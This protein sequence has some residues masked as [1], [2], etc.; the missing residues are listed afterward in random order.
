[1]QLVL[2]DT[3]QIQPYIFSSSRLRENTGASDLVAA[4][5]GDWALDA[6][7]EVATPHNIRAD[8]SLDAGRRIESDADGPEAELVYAGGGNVAVL[9]R[10]P[11]SAEAF[12]R[13]L[14]RR[15]FTEAPELQLVIGRQ[16]FEWGESLADRLDSAFRT[17]AVE[18]RGRRLSAPLF[19]L[20]VS[21][22]CRSTGLPAAGLTPGVAPYP[23]SA[24]ILAKW[25]RRSEADARLQR[26]L[27]PAD[28]CD[29]PADFN[30]LCQ[31]EGEHSY[32][33]VVHADGNG[34][35]E[36]MRTVARQHR[37]PA[38]NRAFIEAIR[39]FS[40][41]L[42]SAGLS[43]LREALSLCPI[44]RGE[45][46]HPVPGK[47]GIS[48][49][50]DRE[51]GKLLLP[52]RP[53]VFGGD[54]VTFVSDGR[55]GLGLAVAYLEEFEKA[56][57]G[58]PGSTA[59]ATACAGV[60]IV[61]SHYPFA[62]A[63][64]LASD[65]CRAAKT[66]RREAH[67]EGSCLDWHFALSGLAGDLNEIRRR[68]Y[69]VP[70]GSLTLRPVSLAANPRHAH[71]SWPVVRAGVAAFQGHGWEGR[72]NKVKALRDALRSGGEAV[73]WFLGRF[74]EGKDL[75]DVELSMSDWPKRGWQGRWCGYFD[76]VEI[77]DW[78][79]PLEGEAH[80]ATGA[81]YH[82]A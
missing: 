19:G 50:T 74:N 21:V 54:D 36:R 57:A 18:K 51:T 2:V 9:F 39:G 10:S 34:T 25:E 32:I 37:E 15:V 64:A 78:F 8:G 77:A 61:K 42:D 14:S 33:A 13:S 63:Y 80:D 66:Y 58:L 59:A 7:R 24:E 11:G 47:P 5:T 60:A 65:L 53:I 3:A 49:A 4:A 70:S 12:M 56:T 72:R 28:G 44:R 20:G 22:M 17:V 16:P 35:G 27:P 81:A 41:A 29:Y 68:E 48:L 67:L 73:R 71:R 69:M 31:S 38:G 52:L 76:A 75:A 30:Q 45:V 79:V 55:L 26:H 46:P 43:A 62:R 23:A 6:V 82:A 1:M 40:Q